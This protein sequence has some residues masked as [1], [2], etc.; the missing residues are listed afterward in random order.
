[1]DESTGTKTEQPT[2]KKREDAKKEGNVAHSAE[3]N[4]VF[5]LTILLIL[6]IA[7]FNSD[8]N[9][10]ASFSRNI[11]QDILTDNL[12]L[13]TIRGNIGAGFMYIAKVLIAPAIIAGCVAYLV[14][15]IQIGGITLAE[16]PFKFD[17]NKFNPV[18]NFKSIFSFKNFVKFIRQLIEIIIMTAVTWFIV[19]K[20]LSSLVQIPYYDLSTILWFL[21]TTLIKIFLVS[22]LINLVASVIDF[23]MEKFNTTKQ[24]MMTPSEIKQENK[25]TQGDAEIKKRR[26]E[27]HREIVGDDGELTISNSTMVLANPTHIAIVLLYRPKRFKLPIIVAKASGSKAQNIFTIAKKHNILIVRDIWLARSLFKIAIVGKYVPSSMLAPVADLISKNLHLL[28]KTA[29]ELAE[30]DKPG[31]KNTSDSRPSSIKI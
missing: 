3:L 28:P 23:I 10:F 19:K 25:N 11:F 15:V 20:S 31:A 21:A 1:M 2:P 12:S 17:L 4:K 7:S 9:Y 13:S 29:T 5:A 27:I 18:N 14:N 16:T 6:F 22:L 30:M 24:L 8:L 26:Q